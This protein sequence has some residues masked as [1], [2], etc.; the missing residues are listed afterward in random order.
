MGATQGGLIELRTLD[1]VALRPVIERVTRLARIIADAPYA[2]VVLVDE[3][4]VWM[5]GFNDEPET[6]R[7]LEDTTTGRRLHESPV[8]FE[9]LRVTA[10]DHRWVAGQPYARFYAN[11]P[12]DL[13]CGLR[14][15]ALC[16]GASITRPRD[17]AVLSQ[18]VDLAALVGEAVGRLRAQRAEEEASRQERAATALKEALM[19]AAPVAIAM[20]DLEQRY[21]YVNERWTHDTGVAAES[22]IGHKVA[23]LFPESYALLKDKYAAGLAG[24]SALAER[25]RVPLPGR[26][27]RWLRAS[28]GPWRDSEGR[29][30]GLV[31]MSHDISDV[32]AGV[33]R[34]ERSEQRL[35]LALEIAE[36]SVYELNY[37]ERTLRVEGAADTFFDQ[38]KTYAELARDIWVT[39]HPEDRPAAQAA[40]ERHMKEGVPFRTEYRMNVPG[41][42]IW[43]FSAAELIRGED[44]RIDGVIGV[45]KNI[46]QR[47][48]SEDTMARARDAAEAA[49]RAK[50]E[51]LAN[52]SHEIRTPL[53]GVMGVSSALART[54]LTPAQ[55]E[56]VGLIE[57]SAQTLEAILADVLD[58]ARVE[59]GRLEVKAEPFDLGACLRQAAALFQPAAEAKG[60]AFDL[61]IAP[62]AGGAFVGDVVRVRQIL[63]NLLSNA[64][65]F[66]AKGAIGLR[67]R[68]DEVGER[69]RL[70]L[71]V[72][73]TG[74]GFSAEV[75]A[76]LFE[77][78]EQADGSITRRYG[79]TGLGLAIS[80]A[81]AKAMD[82]S[83]EAESLPRQGASFT[84]TLMLDRAAPSIAPVALHTAYDLDIDAPP[85]VLLA[86][87]HAINRKV[88]ELLLGHVGVDLTCVENGAD[89]VEAASSGQFDLILMDMQMPIMDGL[90]AIRAIRGHEQAMRRAPTPIWALSANALPEHVEASLAAGADGHLA[91]PISAE[92]L[93]AVL[94]QACAG[95]GVAPAVGLR[96]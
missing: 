28:L 12:V 49:N 29:I 44:G 50:S 45:L 93:F 86:E 51:F 80:R 82:G 33:E 31:S 19:R 37:R 26:P 18:L 81:L 66:T 73:D 52:M 14:V 4:Q 35:R 92:S 91:K 27:N 54:A 94:A 23:D 90:T 3:D 83:L 2:F 11:A 79:G 58:L 17:D 43:A 76:R 38:S 9:D 61:D 70:T 67:A 75:K 65:K 42:E 16:V 53:N 22:A 40:W 8:W 13:A 48:Q 7:P 96:A 6:F 88:V 63:C 25:V 21:I 41:R 24:E 30:G 95:G 56:M 85:R 32:I 1:L 60:L 71:S 15:G 78:F 89:A 20:S 59:S 77:R 47:R 72:T 36:V 69:T 46:T 10:P 39:V 62:R 87:D 64:V 34:T 68:A 55:A 57:T 84:L 74:I 5:S